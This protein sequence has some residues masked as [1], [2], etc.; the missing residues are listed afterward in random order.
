MRGR[1]MACAG[2]TMRR[3]KKKEGGGRGHSRQEQA[4]QLDD[5]TR[6]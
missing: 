4:V 6:Q 3:R 2:R 1:V 5:S